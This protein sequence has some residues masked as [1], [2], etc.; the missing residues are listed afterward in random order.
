MRT[1]AGTE[2]AGGWFWRKT[3]WTLALAIHASR[4]AAADS[5]IPANA[6]VP[7]LSLEELVNI[8]VTSVSRKEER[9]NDAAAAIF[10]LSNDDLRRSGATSVAD[11][12]RLVPGLQV[13][14][15]DAGTWAVSARGFN[16][17]FANKLLVMVDGRTVYS[18][19]FSGVY[20]DTPQVFLDDVDRIEV[21]RGPGAT[22]W[23]A[24]AVNG[25][26]SILTKS[27]KDTQGTLVY[28]GGGDVH[29]ALG[30]AR[31]GGKIG[32]NTYY[33]IFGTYQLNQDFRESSGRRV[34]DGWDLWK[35][36]FRLDHYTAA[37]GQLT[38]LANGY[39]GTPSTPAGDLYGFN[40]LGRWSQHLSDRSSYEIQAFLDRTYRNDSLAKVSLDTA[41]LSFQNTIGLAERNDFIWGLGYRYSD[42]RPTQSNFPALQLVDHDIALS[43]FS[44]FIQDEIKI[45]PDKLKFTLGTKFEH[46]D[47]TGFEVQ[48]SARLAYLPADNQTLWAAVS[49]A[50]RTPSE[51]EGKPFFRFA[52]GF[53]VQGPDGGFYVPTRVS[54][55]N[56]QSEVLWAYELGY[57]VQPTKKV[58]IDVA[59]FYNDYSH[60]VSGLPSNFIPGIP[61]GTLEI[62]PQNQLRGESY[63]GETVLT[64]SVMDSWR[65]SGSYSLLLM[66]IRGELESD[67][68]AYERNAP[69]HQVVLRSSYDLTRKLSFDS[70]LRYVDNVGAIPSYFT[71]DVHLSYRISANLEVSLVGQN[72][73]DGSHPEQA[74]TIGAL[75]REVP[76]GFYG[77]ITW[78]F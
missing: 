58:S 42:A 21:I 39:G 62:L 48:P 12:L 36:G 44:A 31:Y 17:Q 68:Q 41:D 66:H 28:G 3:S 27:A 7:D 52:S 70:Q 55:D 76:R 2:K 73:F 8:K 47:F 49:R 53:P 75:T 37:E 10:V 50:V 38:W 24:N 19:L 59:T 64:V 15:I 71:A 26:I 1:G 56:V 35:E 33:R 4:V 9:L 22:V 61:V 74:S 32:E 65:L 46:N 63:G 45:V 43:L 20:W 69:T 25:V 16:S 13:A 77:K 57:R 34:D 5:S 78:Q 40:T 18:P 23:G 67:A 51:T 11:A 60:L 29:L 6:P 30:G 14:S 54:N 72:L